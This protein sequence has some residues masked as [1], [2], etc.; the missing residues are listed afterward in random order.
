MKLIMVYN[1][2][3]LKQNTEMVEMAKT[4]VFMCNCK[5]SQIKRLYIYVCCSPHLALFRERISIKRLG[6]GK[7]GLAALHEQTLISC[8]N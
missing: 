8:S 1:S 7:H 3:I 6:V 5:E 4:Y 2:T